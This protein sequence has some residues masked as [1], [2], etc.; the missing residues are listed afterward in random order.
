MDSL[1]TLMDKK[2]YELV[3]KLT[4]DS[5]TPNDIFYRVASFVALN[6][7][8]EALKT[9]ESKRAILETQLPILMK[10][11]IELLVT[12]GRY[13]KAKE[14]MDHYE[15]LP[16]FSQEAEERIKSIK[17]YIQKAEKDS[18]HSN[19][20]DE[21][22]IREYLTS[23]KEEIVLAGLQSLKDKDIRVYIKDIEKM[24]MSTKKQSIRSFALM[25]LVEK[26]YDQKVKFLHE[27]TIME[28]IP[29]DLKQPF[30]ADEFKQAIQKMTIKYKDPVI[31]N[32]S[33]NVLST[34]IIYN[35]PTVVK[36]DC[37][38][39][40]E[41]LFEISIRYLGI[42]DYKSLEERCHNENIDIVKVRSIIEKI[43]NALSRF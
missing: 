23:D 2:N 22:K 29:K 36:F 26:Q 10:M 17:Q 28:L 38:E 42:K 5:D 18:Y 41:A 24:M 6:K 40:L 7:P 14:E 3:I 4:A 12:L 13:E 15:N 16:Y 34:Y 39:M 33:I 43:E 8:E 30:V 32:N 11:H 21:D 27:D 19:V 31:V 35:Y 9:I 37:D 20:L 25:M 1:K